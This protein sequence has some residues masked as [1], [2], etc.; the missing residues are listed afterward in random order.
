VDCY[1]KSLTIM[2][3]IHDSLGLGHVYHDLALAHFSLQDTLKSLSFFRA[4][5][6]ISQAMTNHPNLG[7]RELNIAEF[8]LKTGKPDKARNHYLISLVILGD[9]QD[10]YNLVHVLLAL[11][12]IEEAETHYKKAREYFVRATR[13]AKKH[14]LPREM[15]TAGYLLGQLFLDSGNLELSIVHLKEALIL[16]TQKDDRELKAKILLELSSCYQRGQ[17]EEKAFRYYQHYSALKDSIRADNIEKQ[18]S[19]LEMKYDYNHKKNELNLL[20]EENQLRSV[21][22]NKQKRIQ[23]YGLIIAL[24]FLIAAG[25]SILFF[26]IRSKT[27][28]LVHEKSNQLITT[29][30]KLTISKQELTSITETKNNLFT[31]LAEQLIQPFKELVNMT[32]SLSSNSS[33]MDTEEIKRVS[34][35]IHHNSKDLHDLLKN[36]L[37]WSRI[38]T[39]K[40]ILHPET[41]DLTRLAEL[42]VSESR[43]IADR[44]RITLKTSLIT[45]C[46]VFSDSNLITIALRNIL[47]NTI[48]N[49]PKNGLITVKTFSEQ[50]IAVIQITDSGTGISKED[51]H[52]LFKTDKKFTIKGTSEEKGISLGLIV[53]KEFVALNLGQI[54]IDS[55]PGNGSTFTVT[56]P[57]TP[58]KVQNNS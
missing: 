5:L 4:A 40:V 30:Q 15:A 17:N 1:E 46:K 12:Q 32:E 21:K 51:Q 24:F 43:V 35:Q 47:K 36:L 52:K 8:Y 58:P 7:I 56:L 45:S 9:Q 41:T 53:A 33:D 49:T 10:A 50:D 29:H 39:H 14:Q 27:L 11:G 54:K 13:E 44:N 18:L 28:K 34:H 38:Q 6:S 16:T 31:I 25:I 55:K 3:K 20:Q 48:K 23:Q 42:V 26:L 2:Q 22:L 57:K 19:F 37:H